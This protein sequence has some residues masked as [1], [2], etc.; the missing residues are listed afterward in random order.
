MASAEPVALF[1]FAH[2]DDEFGVFQQI[3]AER[4][5]GRR[6]F[7]AYLTDG[8]FGGASPLRRNRESMAVLRQMGVQKQDIFFPGYSLSIPD[9][10]LPEHLGTA[11]NW[12]R[13][14]LSN[15]SRV[16]AIYVPAW[17]GGH[18]DHDALHA[19]TVSL[20]EAMGILGLVRQFPLYN[21]YGCIGPM[22]RVF[23]PLPLNG[24]V[25]KTRIPWRNRLRF[26]RYCLSYRSQTSAWL[27]L[28]PFVVLYYLGSGMQTLQPVSGE[29]IGQRPHEGP[30]YYE[31]RGF[32]TWEKMAACLAAWRET[33]LS[34]GK[35]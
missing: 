33:G 10:G 4:S 2:Q 12:V 25:K 14:W 20:T 31:R 34:F 16:E 24:A 8:S 3:I 29:R 1:L 6:V 9:A 23:M 15:S 17:E 18:H 28:F 19:I 35:K 32:F 21:G 22:F 30:L 13:E 27:G 7:C 26:L 11:A 5:H